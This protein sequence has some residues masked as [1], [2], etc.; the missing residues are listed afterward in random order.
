MVNQL[1]C[2]LAN[3]SLQTEP[4][5]ATAATDRSAAA[6]ELAAVQV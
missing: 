5:A 1:F 4:Q 6:A 3:V 2:L